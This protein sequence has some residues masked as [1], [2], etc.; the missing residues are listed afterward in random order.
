M[1]DK[2]NEKSQQKHFSH[3]EGN[4]QSFRTDGSSQDYSQKVG[5]QDNSMNDKATSYGQSQNLSLI[6]I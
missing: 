6:H 4:Q 5:N 2:M 1:N 3:N